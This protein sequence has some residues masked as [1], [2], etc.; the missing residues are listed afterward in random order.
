MTG[1]DP[2]T[3]PSVVNTIVLSI[4][5]CID[6][7]WV[8]AG[9]SGIRTVPLVREGPEHGV[10][11]HPSLQEALETLDDEIPVATISDTVA[12]RKAV[13]GGHLA[14]GEARRSPSLTHTTVDC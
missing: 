11:S 7:V 14:P 5:A 4:F 10:D 8:V 13:A 9:P 6:Q 12:H 1:N 2:E 3:N